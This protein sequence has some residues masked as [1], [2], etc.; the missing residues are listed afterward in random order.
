MEKGDLHGK[1]FTQLHCGCLKM[2]TTVQVKRLWTCPPIPQPLPQESSAQTL[3]EL[4]ILSPV[5]AKIHTISL[6]L[7]VLA[8]SSLCSRHSEPPAMP[9]PASGN[10]LVLLCTWNIPSGTGMTCGQ[11]LHL[12]PS[13]L[14]NVNLSATSC[15]DLCIKLQPWPLTSLIHISCFVLLSSHHLTHHLCM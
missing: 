14:S 12:F 9:G 13:L 3:P 15:N 4:P 6:H 8:A 11:L 5:K 1:H 7:L 10:R 2:N